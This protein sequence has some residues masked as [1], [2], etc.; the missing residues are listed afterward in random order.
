MGVRLDTP[1]SR[2]GDIVE[3]LKEVRWELDIRGFNH[4]KIFVSGGLTD[5]SVKELS[6]AGA[7]GFGVGTWICNAP[8][9]DFALDIVEVEGR[10]A[11]KRG[12]LS[13]RKSV[14]RCPSCTSD[15]V[16]REGPSV[17][18]CPRCKAEMEPL[19]LPLIR[20]GRIVADLPQVS[21]IRERCLKQL[22]RFE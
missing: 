22:G 9:V 17:P 1:R 18:S 21:K 11:A 12:K 8:T 3:I 15:L 13:G 14:W 5:E 4:V 10:F 2:R 19:L 16:L 20:G 7:D 6:E